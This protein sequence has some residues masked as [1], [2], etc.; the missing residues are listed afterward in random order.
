MSLSE[1]FHGLFRPLRLRSRRP[2]TIDLYRTTIRSFE[3][4]LG[5][6]AQL[7]DLDDITVS[8]YLTWQRDRDLSPYSVEKERANLLCMWRFAAQ[9]AL[10]TIWPNVEREV[11]PNRIPSAWVDSEIESLFTAC[12]NTV[13]YVGPVKAGLW[14]T[15]LHYLL[16]DT[17]ERI[18]AV[19]GLQWRD[20]DL[21]RHWVTFRA[22]T[23]KGGRTDRIYPIAAD[24]AEA[25]AKLPRGLGKVLE[26]PYC[27]TYLWNRYAK[28]LKRAG[29][30]TDRL[31]KFH[32]V[33]R[34]VASYYEAGGGD[35]TELLG[36]SSRAVTRRYLD[37]RIVGAV[38]AIK[39]LF[40]PVKEKV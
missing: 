3:R 7:T 35:A 5:R 27:S 20:V 11:C 15:A 21:Q 1:F 14:W 32:R 29:L 38:S 2:R 19:V 10:L 36:H 26:W 40:R 30:P 16:W 24:T 9:R 18:G 28:I 4:F 31:S 33:R 34:S 8:S 25:L 12:G 17:G 6:A 22:E 39:I 37:P 13:G 23:R